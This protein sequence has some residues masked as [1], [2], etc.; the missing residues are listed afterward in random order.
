MAFDGGP[1]IG[2]PLLE[3]CIFGKCC[4]RPLKN[5]EHMT[6]QSAILTMYSCRVPDL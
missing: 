5:F 4:L 3:K 1:S 6:F 2:M